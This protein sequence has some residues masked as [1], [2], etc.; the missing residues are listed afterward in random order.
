MALLRRTGFPEGFIEFI[1]KFSF[2]LEEHCLELRL[3]L[4]FN[5][6]APKM[7]AHASVK[8]CSFSKTMVIYIIIQKYL[9]AKSHK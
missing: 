7:T 2:C 1:S 9:D 5:K 3:M 6:H 8:L 4:F